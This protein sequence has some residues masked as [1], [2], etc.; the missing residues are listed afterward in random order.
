MDARQKT[1]LAALLGLIWTGLV[2]WQW[3]TSEE[4]ARAPLTNVSGLPA[5]GQG[6]REKT[7]GIRVNLGL[8]AAART[9]REA[10]FTAP[11]NIFAVPRSDG[12]LPVGGEAIPAVPA[13]AVSDQTLAEQ[14]AAVELAQYRYL[15][16]L[17]MSEGRNRKKD[18]AVLSKNEEV[19]VVKVGDRVEDH[20]VLK[21]ITPESVTIRDTGARIEQTL[22]LSEESPPQP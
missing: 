4:P 10:T 6:I 5:S 15:G 18:V 14:A 13:A 3:G 20:L 21:A 1:I 11:R 8:L 7:Q 12:T 17:R 22:P 19:M 16:Y 9:Q 2:L